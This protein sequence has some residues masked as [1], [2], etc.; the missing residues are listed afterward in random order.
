MKFIITPLLLAILAFNVQAATTDT[1]NCQRKDELAKCLQLDANQAKKFDALMTK[2]RD[3][4]DKIR[5]ERE[6]KREENQE[7]V[8]TLRD[9]QHKELAALLTPSQLAAFDKME[10]KRRSHHKGH[11]HGRGRDDDRGGRDEQLR[12]KQ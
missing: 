6:K 5:D 10:K 4:M 3:A 8:K 7:A 1:A 9:N 2:H 12:D 11:G